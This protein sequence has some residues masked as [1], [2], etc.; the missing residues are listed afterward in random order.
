MTCS[1]RKKYNIFWIYQFP[2]CHEQDV[3]VPQTMVQRAK[4]K[5]PKAPGAPRGDVGLGRVRWRAT[6]SRATCWR[7]FGPGLRPGTNPSD[8]GSAE[9]V[10]SETHFDN[11][12]WSTL[13]MKTDKTQWALNEP[14]LSPQWAFTPNSMSFDANYFTYNISNNTFELIK[15]IQ[16]I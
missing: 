9:N 4:A 10:H 5:G 15:H 6:C 12:F 8:L 13:Y 3:T 16:L 7:Y 1:L 11:I 2:T 14:L